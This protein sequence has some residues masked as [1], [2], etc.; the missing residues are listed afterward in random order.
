M[1]DFVECGKVMVVGVMLIFILIIV[2][3]DMICG[4][5]YVLIGGIYGFGFWIGFGVWYL[6][7][8]VLII[9]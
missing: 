4:V 1:I 8:C 7:M 9:K 2:V 3:V 5:I 6:F